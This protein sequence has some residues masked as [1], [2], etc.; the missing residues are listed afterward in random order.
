MAGVADA[1]FRYQCRQ[2]QAGLS[3][4]EMLT[5]DIGLWHQPK[6]QW[7]LRWAKNET[8]ISVQ[9]AGTDPDAMARAAEQCQA[10]GAAIIDINMGCP[11]KKVCKK[12]A[13]SALMGDERRAQQILRAVINATDCPVTL[14]TRT[15]LEPSLKSAVSLAQLAQAEGVLAITIHGRSRACKFNGSA[16]HN[17]VKLVKGSVSIP[18]FANGDI[19]TIDEAKRVLDETGADGIMIGRGALGRPWLFA[20]VEQFLVHGL[21]APEPDLWEKYNVVSKHLRDIH[22]FY[23]SEVGVRIA[24]KHV[25]WYM[26]YLPKG[27]L[28]CQQFNRL[29]GQSEQL[30]LLLHF[31]ELLAVEKRL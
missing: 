9:I 12:M 11:A 3:T 8:P 6:S 13:G 17:T 16:E 25:R 23:G 15:G 18:V 19:K 1:P 14:K 31:F 5:S 27:D 29:A 28:F 10:R 20:Q 7:R 2:F 21:Q 22:A 30:A 26:S 4:S 24:R